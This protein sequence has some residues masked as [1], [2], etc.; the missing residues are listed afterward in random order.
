MNRARTSA[1]GADRRLRLLLPLRHQ[2]SPPRRPT[3][4][5]A[6]TL[7]GRTDEALPLL[8]QAAARRRSHQGLRVAYL[9][10][11]Y[12]LAGRREDALRCARQAL[13]LSRDLSEQGHEAWALRLLGQVHAQ[14]D[15]PK[16]EQGE[17]AFG[18]AMALAQE[19]GMRPLLARCH[20]G[21]GTLYRRIGKPQQAREHLTTAATMLHEMDMGFWLAEAEAEIKKLD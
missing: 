15:P 2:N 8:E 6:Y 11:A 16:A 12:L 9:G 7:A 1:A 19:L 18:Q 5:S 13:A 17:A 3:L 21:L 14:G 20:L 10:E 4:G